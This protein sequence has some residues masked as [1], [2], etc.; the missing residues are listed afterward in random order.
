M[1]GHW[2]R[3][4]DSP[5]TIARTVATTYRTHLRTANPVVCDRIDDAMRAF[6]QLW[7]VSQVITTEADSLV[8]T[9][10]AAELAGVTPA[11]VHQ[12][13]RRGYVDRSGERRYLS[14]Y[15]SDDR[16]WP[17]FLAAEILEIVAT[18]R[19]RQRGA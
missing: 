1:T 17:L 5:V 11:T 18:T 15:G 13:R 14:T 7:V 10:A 19:A 6:G 16:G 9:T 8:G 4:G 2:P 12:W 3:S